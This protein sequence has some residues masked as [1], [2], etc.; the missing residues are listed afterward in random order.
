MSAINAAIDYAKNHREDFLAELTEFLAIPSI[1]TLPEHTGDIQRCAEWLATQLTRMGMKEVAVMPTG[2][3]PVVY[4]EWLGA[5]GKPT[6]LIYGHYD[7]QPAD[8]LGEWETPPFEPTIRGDYIVARGASDMKSQLFAL[9]KALDS[10]VQQGDPPVNLKFVLEGEEEVGSPNLESF[11]HKNA[12]MLSA[13]VVLNCDSAIYAPD[14]PSLVYSLRGLAYFELHL[15]GPRQDLHS[16]MFGGVVHNPAQVLCELIAAMHDDQGRVTL[17]GFY[18]TVRTMDDA[19][20]ADIAKSAKSD[21]RWLEMSGAPALYGESGFTPTERAG[22]RPTLEVN[23]MIS[24]FTGEGSKTVLPAKAMAKISCRL[25]ADQDPTVVAQQLETFVREHAP[26]TVTWSIDQHAGAPPGF[27]DRETPWMK[28]AQE[29][30]KEVFGKTPLFTRQGGTIPIVG[31]MK[32]ILGIDSVLMGFG[33][34]DD[35]IHGPNE[36]QYLPNVYKGIE[37]YIRYLDRISQ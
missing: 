28:H 33:L 34:P 24:G 32:T 6:V 15:R 31:Y 7:V 17:P 29:S 10:I 37:T 20:R 11:L 22:A 21:E 35:G 4:G 9:L 5:P 14:T 1:S 23:G 27:T 13:D 36:R 12:D 16:G 30:M 3:H 26:D 2:G 25:V 18:D 8:P 19:E